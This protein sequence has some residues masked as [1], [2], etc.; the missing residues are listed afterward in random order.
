M[1]SSFRQVSVI[2]PHGSHKIRRDNARFPGSIF[3]E[4]RNTGG[5]IILK[6]DQEANKL[7]RISGTRAISTKSRRELSSSFFSSKAK[8]RRKFK[9]FWQKHLLVSFLVRLRT[10]QH[11]CIRITDY[12]NVN[13]VTGNKNK[14]KVS[15]LKALFVEFIW[16][17]HF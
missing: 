9:P 7:G 17:K 12:F 2:S 14:S 10:Y 15:V 6:P 8:R 3:N 11:A 16:N 1:Q 13:R 4:P 5:L